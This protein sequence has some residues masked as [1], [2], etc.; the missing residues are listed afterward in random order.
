[1]EIADKVIDFYD[2]HGP[3]A[4]VDPGGCRQLPQRSDYGQGDERPGAASS[5]T[6]LGADYQGRTGVKVQSRCR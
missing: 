6:W 2:Q 1:M 5:M 3:G 4:L